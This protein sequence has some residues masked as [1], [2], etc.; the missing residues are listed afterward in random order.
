VSFS[1]ITIQP[2]PAVVATRLD[3]FGNLATSF[4]IETPHKTLE[5]LA[6][7]E[8][9]S[10]RPLASL[11][12]VDESADAP[13][14]A[15]QAGPRSAVV[16]A[17]SFLLASPFVPAMPPL[18]DWVRE[19]WDPSAGLVDSV[20]QLMRRIHQEFVFDPQATS[21]ATPLAQVFAQRRGVCQDFAHLAIASLRSVGVP[22]R[23]VSGYLETIPP[24]G[25][26]RLVGADASHAWVQFYS[27]RRGWIDFDPTNNQLPAVSH[28]VLAWGRDY[29]DVTPLKGV[30]VGSAHH[31][32]DVSVDV[33]RIGP[34]SGSLQQQ[35]IQSSQQ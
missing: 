7:S 33:V 19:S 5:V 24:E 15:I 35:Q 4:S 20:R 31:V 23:Y 17:V 28:I 10:S 1:C 11:V 25:H 29:S 26:E 32:L 12:D 2:T 9:D 8:V 6:T 34:D 14:Q 3:I 27:P 30:I 21:V 13:R 18:T 16:D 22:A